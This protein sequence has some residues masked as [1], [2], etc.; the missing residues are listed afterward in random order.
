MK[1]KTNLKL[2]ARQQYELLY[3]LRRAL[4]QSLRYATGSEDIE[5]ELN[6]AVFIAGHALG[7]SQAVQVAVANS[8]ASAA[9]WVYIP[10]IQSHLW[11]SIENYRYSGSW[12]VP[13]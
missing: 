11:A 9:Q 2:T 5:F 12:K 1:R 6:D 7:M 13:F 8:A 4:A 10:T 3:R